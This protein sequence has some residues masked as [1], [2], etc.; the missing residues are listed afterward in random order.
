MLNVE[1]NDELTLTYGKGALRDEGDDSDDDN[2]GTVEKDT[3]LVDVVIARRPK[4]R[5]SNAQV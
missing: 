5:K 3:G 1:D 2:D 4:S